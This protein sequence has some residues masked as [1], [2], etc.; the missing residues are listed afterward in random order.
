MNKLT[1]VLISVIAV[2]VVLLVATI[3][4]GAASEAG[5]HMPGIIGI[6]LFAGLYGGLKAMWKGD[7]KSKD[8]KKDISDINDDNS[9]SILQK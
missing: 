5:H 4:A 1:K 7:K 9:N 6:I 8:E 3:L 2:F